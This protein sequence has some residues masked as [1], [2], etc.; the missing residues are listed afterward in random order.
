MDKTN[1][2]PSWTYRLINIG[3]ATL[4]LPLVVFALFASLEIVLVLA[5][6]A[7]AES[8]GDGVAGAMPWSRC[9]I[10]GCS[11]AARCRWG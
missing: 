9:A 2:R 1:E 6:Q 5:A 8:A 11:S 4:A 7:I 3:L 10:S